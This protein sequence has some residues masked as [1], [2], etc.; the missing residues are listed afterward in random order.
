MFDLTDPDSWSNGKPLHHDMEMVLAGIAD[1]SLLLLADILPTGIFA[2]VQA[3]N[4]PKV[5]PVITGRPWPLSF[6]HEA[7]ESISSINLKPEDG[8]LTFAVIGLGPVGICT[9][10]SLLD[11]LVTRNLPFRVVAIDPLEARRRKMERVLAT[12]DQQAKISGVFT[13]QSIDDAGKTVQEW[14]AGV[15]CNAILEVSETSLSAGRISFHVHETQVVGN[16]SALKLGYDLVRAFGAIISVG[17]HGEPQIPFTGQQLYNKNVSLD[18]GRCP[19]Q[20]MFPL[21]FDL[22]G[23]S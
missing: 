12:I 11:M 7:D 17:V 19:A 21:A 9:C 18:F 8:I 5:L 20:A 10:V 4:H 1:S 14:T 6:H 3:L 2:A 22:L 16:N 23:M 13:V 15:G